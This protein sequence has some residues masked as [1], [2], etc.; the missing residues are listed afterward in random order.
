MSIAP[1]QVYDEGILIPRQYIDASGGLE[2]LV[3]DEFVVLRPKP[4]EA[5]PETLYSPSSAAWSHP[6]PA[7]NVLLDFPKL[8]IAQSTFPT[9]PTIRDPVW[10][11]ETHKLPEAL[12]MSPVV[13]PESALLGLLPTAL[14]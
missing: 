7:S 6:P 14:S 10:C 3:T 11:S 4:V 5:N 9:S 13:S 8:S 1:I 12:Q 2:L